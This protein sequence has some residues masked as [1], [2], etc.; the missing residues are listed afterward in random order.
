MTKTSGKRRLLPL[1]ALVRLGGLAIFFLGIAI[2][3]S[4]LRPRGRLAAARRDH[5]DHGRDRRHIRAA[6]A[7][8]SVGRAGPAG[9]VKRFWKDVAVD[10]GG[11]R[12][13]GPPRRPAAANAGARAL[14]VP[15]EALAD[16]IAEE[17]RA[18]EDEID[19]RAMPL[20]GLA[21]AAIDRVAPDPAGVRG[22]LGPLRRGR[23]RLLSR[24]RAAR[25]GRAPGG[26]AGMRCWPG[27]GGATMSISR[28]RRASMHVPQPAATVERLGHAVAALDPFRLA[29]LSPLVTIGG[30]LVAALAVLE[31]AMSADEAWDA[32][33]IDERWQLEQWGAD[34]EAE[35]ALDNRRRDF[36]AA[37]RIPGACSTASAAALDQVADEVDQVGLADRVRA[38]RRR[39]SLGPR[40]RH[41]VH[42]VVDQHIFI[43]GPVADLAGGAA[44]PVGDHLFRIGAARV[45]ASLQLLH[46][47]RQ[48][49]D[50]DQIARRTP[51]SSCCVPCQSMSNRMSRPSSSASLIGAFGRA[52][53]MV[54]HMGPFDELVG[55]DQPVELGVVDE[56][57][58]DVVDL[59]GPLR[60]GGRATPTW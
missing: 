22:G 10:A 33:S 23:P 54:E 4:N 55:L 47:R 32:V 26:R 11:G 58:I 44:H 57:I 15:T 6:T 30:S 21:N 43:F 17:W 7:Q 20:T 39:R 35:A 40:A 46:R 8:A 51:R 5:R 25:A 45:Q 34:A 28:P 49:E 14:I 1:F 37:A 2:A 9:P 48:D 12:L 3:Y 38:V 18:V 29:G 13:G 59:A 31:R 42:V 19:P 41:C 27:R 53:A 52:V 16:A 56:M 36:L 24:G 60:P 50:A